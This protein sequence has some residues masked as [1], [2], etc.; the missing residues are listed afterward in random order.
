[1]RWEALALVVA[2]VMRWEALVLVVALVMRWG[3]FVPDYVKFMLH[4]KSLVE[5]PHQS[6]I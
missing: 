4:P 2:P 5:A 1:M 6:E 3:N